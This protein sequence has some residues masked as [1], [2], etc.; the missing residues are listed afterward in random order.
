MANSPAAERGLKLLEKCALFSALDGKARLE[1]A[2][3]AHPR[4][5]AAGD[6]IC[7]IDEHGDS[8]MAV[9]LGV[10]R[11]SLPAVR[12]KEIILADLGAGEMFGEI[13]LLDGK[14]RSANATAHTNCEL[15]VLERRDVLP[16]LE[17]NPA[18]C[19][20]LMAILCA[21]IRRSDERMS[22]IAFFDLPARLAKTLLSYPAQGHGAAKLSLSQRELAEMSGG[23]RENVN[24]C[25]RDWQR[26]GIL[27]LKDRWTIILKPEA[28]RELVTSP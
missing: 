13:A 12:G 28:L 24:R 1:L 25:L 27:E 3:H 6:P 19:M 23:T 18:A 20:K 26:R 4:H 9:V 2:A 21:R 8:M 22:D 5:F 16:F 14:P 11:I 10:V 17:R 7:R 15:M